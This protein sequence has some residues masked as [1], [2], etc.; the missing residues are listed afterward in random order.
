V[1]DLD[2]EDS[3][4]MKTDAVDRPTVL[5]VSKTEYKVSLVMCFCGGY[6][7]MCVVMGEGEHVHVRDN[8]CEGVCTEYE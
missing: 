7:C 8:V 1:D 3:I 5:P 4:H 2:E 6:L